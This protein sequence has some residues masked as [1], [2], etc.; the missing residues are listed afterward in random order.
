[1]LALMIGYDFWSRGRPHPATWLGALAIFASIGAA[2]AIG[3]STAGFHFLHTVF[4][5]V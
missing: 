1:L 2:V 5:R 3:L 4:A